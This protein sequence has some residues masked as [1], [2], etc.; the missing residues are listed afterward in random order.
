MR[1]AFVWKTHDYLK[2]LILKMVCCVI[3]HSPANDPLRGPAHDYCYRCG[4]RMKPQKHLTISEE[5]KD[6]LLSVML[7]LITI[8]AVIGA[9][10]TFIYMIGKQ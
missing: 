9:I 8:V 10:V 7:F 4:K 2:E 6:L 1:N 3:S 5:H